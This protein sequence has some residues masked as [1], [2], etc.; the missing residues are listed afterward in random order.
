MSNRYL[1][2][3][4][5]AVAIMRGDARAASFLRSSPEVYLCD[6]V[7]G[8]LYF[9]AYRSDRREVNLQRVAEFTSRF[10][11]IYGSLRA[12]QEYGNLKAKLQ[13][14][15]TLLPEN[16]MWIAAIAIAYQLVLATRDTHFERIPELNR[17]EW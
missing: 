16:D 9:G 15:G 11:V 4:S 14:E 6:V 13:A 12:T 7:V 1:L 2:D 10:E 5:V 17:A 8:E 3:T